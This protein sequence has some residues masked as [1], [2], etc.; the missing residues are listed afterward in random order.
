MK[1]RMAMATATIASAT[2][3][4]QGKMSGVIWKMGGLIKA[5]KGHEN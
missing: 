4:V 1:E 3:K 2:T 5:N